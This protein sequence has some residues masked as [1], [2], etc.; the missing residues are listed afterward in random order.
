MTIAPPLSQEH[1]RAWAMK[2]KAAN[3]ELA[4]SRA[5]PEGV[6]ETVREISDAVSELPRGD[7][8]SIDPYLF[9]ALQSGL[10]SSMSAL[11]ESPADKV[12][13]R[14]RVSL[15]QARQALRDLADEAPVSED[16]SSKEVLQW[17]NAAL[18]VQQPLLADLVGVDVRTLQ[19]WL[20]PQDSAEPRGDREF[21]IRALAQ[22][23]K[24][25]RHAFSGPGV[26]EWLI[27]KRS[28]LRG[29]APLDLID[30]PEALPQVTT[31]ASQARST[32]AT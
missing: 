5:V 9:L 16:R 20:S 24:H 11:F 31:L 12:R 25:L 18:R 14:L 21:R 19:R 30:K 32:I 8:E 23:T 29:R 15:E 27:R 3:D 17:L 6:R 26:A 13:R 4:A 22:V 2:L 1:M 10:L 7:L 28:D